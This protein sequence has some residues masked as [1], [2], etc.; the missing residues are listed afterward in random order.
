MNTE[1]WGAM[2]TP[3][4]HHPAVPCVCTWHS[5]MCS[6][7]ASPL[8]PSRASPWLG[9]PS[10]GGVLVGN[11]ELSTALPNALGS[12]IIWCCSRADI[13]VKSGQ[14]RG[15]WKLYGEVFLT[16]RKALPCFQ[17]LKC[18]DAS[19]PQL[20]VVCG[21]GVLSPKGEGWM[22]GRGKELHPAGYRVGTVSPVGSGQV[23]LLAGRGRDA[24]WAQ[25][26][27]ESRPS[28]GAGAR[29]C[30]HG[31]GHGWMEH[32]WV[33]AGAVSCSGWGGGPG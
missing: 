15:G 11:S 2:G 33:H 19:V 22:Q 7:C 28:V 31:C 25:V 9:R 14:G 8:W 17:N 20:A 12:V 1:L 29:G 24:G 26:Q 18:V 23:Q 4:F 3:K 32:G 13:G 6:E 21:S 10:L 30:G 27:R 16:K 5:H